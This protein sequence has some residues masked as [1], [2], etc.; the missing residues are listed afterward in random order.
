MA[1]LRPPRQLSSEGL[2]TLSV[3]L[4]EAIAG[5]GAIPVAT[6]PAAAEHERLRMGGLD[7]LRMLAAVLVF[8]FHLTVHTAIDFGP[9]TVFAAHARV[10]VIMFF[11]LSGYLLI[12]PFLYSPVSLRSYALRRLARILP[13]YYLALVGSSLLLQ[14]TEV[15]R[16]PLEYL[17][18]TQ[19]YDPA[20]TGNF[21]TVSW[22]LTI[23]LAFYAVVPLIALGLS[24]LRPLRAVEAVCIGMAASLAGIF[25]MMV[26]YRGPGLAFLLLPFFMWAFGFGILLAVV[27]RHWP[28]RLRRL[29]RWGLWI[30]AA[31]LILALWIGAAAPIDIP[32]A[33]AS[34]FL[35]AALRRRT[36]PSWAAALGNRC[37]Y[38]FYLWHEQIIQ[39]TTGFMAGWPVAFIAGSAAIAVSL[40]SYQIVE[41]PAQRWAARQS[42][43]TQA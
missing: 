19:N 9:L 29:E 41:R 34:F 43:R 8:V 42:R 23:E 35:V 30:G 4:E 10:G 12:R 36:V 21:V 40:V 6:A 24:A 27:E 20:A 15:L 28:A 18:L 2:A 25:A 39:A 37:S 11:V 32:T 17:T 13:A 33:G 14:N 26:L 7:A 1:A 38:S 3:G 31:L 22:T 5:P 16:F